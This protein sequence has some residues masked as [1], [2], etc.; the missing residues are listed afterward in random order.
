M[1][2]MYTL[3]IENALGVDIH[4]KSRAQ[5]DGDRVWPQLISR[6]KEKKGEG[7][8]GI[9]EHDLVIC[10]TVAPQLGIGRKEYTEGKR[11]RDR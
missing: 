9:D 3:R 10:D 2:R 1:R 8:G 4:R 5:G 7:G 11:V 6:G